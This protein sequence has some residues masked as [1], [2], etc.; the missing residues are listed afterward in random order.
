M[1][2]DSHPGLRPGGPTVPSYN[3]KLWPWFQQEDSNR[4]NRALPLNPVRRPDNSLLTVSFQL[5]DRGHARGLTPQLARPLDAGHPREPP[6]TST[7][8]P[9]VTPY[10][11]KPITALPSFDYA[12]PS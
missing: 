6:D 4:E 2:T 9:E 3:S 11:G 5:L 8:T 10:G 7:G 12:E 1:D